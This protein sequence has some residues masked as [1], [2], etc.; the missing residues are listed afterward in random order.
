VICVQERPSVMKLQALRLDTLRSIEWSDTTFVNNSVALQYEH[1]TLNDLGYLKGATLFSKPRCA[2]FG[3]IETHIKGSLLIVD[4]EPATQSA[5]LSQIVAADWILGF[6]NP[7]QGRN[8]LLDVALNTMEAAI[9][10]YATNPRQEWIRLVPLEAPSLSINGLLNSQVCGNDTTHASCSCTVSLHRLFNPALFA[11]YQ[12]PLLLM[13]VRVSSSTPPNAI[14]Q[15]KKVFYGSLPSPDLLK[16]RVCINDIGLVV[17]HTRDD[18]SETLNPPPL[19]SRPSF[20]SPPPPRSP[21]PPPPILSLPPP[22][23]PPQLPNPPPP[24]QPHPPPLKPLPQPPK[25]PP[26]LQ[27]PQ[28]NPSP[29]SPHPPP[30]IL[31]TPQWTVQLMH[32]PCLREVTTGSSLRFPDG[33]G[34]V[35]YAVPDLSFFKSSCH[36]SFDMMPHNWKQD[37][38]ASAQTFWCAVD[39]PQVVRLILTFGGPSIQS[40][41]VWLNGTQVLM[42]STNVHSLAVDAQIQDSHSISNVLL[43]PQGCHHT[44]VVFQDKPPLDRRAQVQS[45]TLCAASKLVHVIEVHIACLKCCLLSMVLASNSTKFVMI[46]RLVLEYRFKPMMF[47]FTTVACCSHATKKTLFVSCRHSRL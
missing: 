7:T 14:E 31:C 47:C 22:S 38:C 39:G 43:L 3:C 40:P 20:P 29:P 5:F 37:Y 15:A 2:M 6:L 19:P 10:Q 33:Q 45:T 23:P 35:S 21:S 1:A 36:H 30:S 18:C 24:H 41:T 8:S 4:A 32:G 42:N 46:D 13:D 26:T 44:E 28:P 12:V 11:V 9:G 16:A 25:S 34:N 27:P 17:S